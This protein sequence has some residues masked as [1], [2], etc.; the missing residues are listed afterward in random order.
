MDY[1][2]RL[3]VVPSQSNRAQSGG[4]NLRD[5]T[6]HY[7]GGRNWRSVRVK[8]KVK[9]RKICV[10]KK[11]EE[12][13]WITFQRKSYKCKWSESYCLTSNR[14]PDVASFILLK[15]A[16]RRYRYQY[17]VSGPSVIKRSLP[18]C[19]VNVTRLSAV[20]WPHSVVYVNIYEVFGGKKIESF[21]DV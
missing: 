15:W 1:S 21:Y 3:N 19:S 18:R 5:G 20:T 17:R 12:G 7:R 9:K 4:T 8:V 11:G 14:C 2:N 6:N 10:E 13:S 16:M